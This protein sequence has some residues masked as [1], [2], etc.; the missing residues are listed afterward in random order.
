MSR[1]YYIG[2]D[3]GS[4][5]IKIV[6]LDEG[7]NILWSKYERTNGDP[8]S[9]LY[10]L[11]RQALD[12]KNILEI[13]YFSAI[14][15]TGS[16][17]SVI[18]QLL[19][20]HPINE[21]SSHGLAAGH[22]FPN[23][24]T[25]IE[26][27]GQD[28]KL[29]FLDSNNKKT[30]IIDSQMNDICAAG[31]GSFLD[32][33]AYRMGIT[34]EELSAK[35]CL[36]NNPSKISGRCSVFAKTDMIHLHQGGTSKEDVSYGLCLAVARTYIENLL[37]GRAVQKPI[38][39]QGG[40]A[41]NKGIKRAFKEL[42]EIS[43]EDIIIPNNFDLMGAIGTIIYGIEKNIENGLSREQLLEALEKS[44]II[45]D[46]DHY[47]PKLTLEN[48]N[49]I[50]I[51]PPSSMNDS[52][53]SGYIGIDIGSVSVKMAV[54][55]DDGKLFFSHYAKNTGDPLISLQECF[56][57][58][59]DG[60][61]EYNI[62]GVGVTGSGRDY[63]GK[64]LKADIV[65]NEI[66]AQVAGTRSQFAGV[67]VI[68]EI[69]GQDSKYIRLK[70]GI[71]DDFVMNKTCAAGTGSFL[72]EQADRL[73][74]ELNN[75]FS[76]FAMKAEKPVNIGSRCTV[77][78]ETDCIHYQQCGIAKEN[79]IAGLSYSIVKNYLEKVAINKSFEGCVAIQGGVANNVSVVA[80]F[81]ALLEKEI[82]ITPN[83]EIT[84]AIGIACIT[85]E[86]MKG[87]KS[88]FIGFNLDE[89]LIEKKHSQCKEC[90]N[91][92]NLTIT[93]FSDK[94]CTVTGAICGK[95]D[96]SN[97]NAIKK[98]NNY[99]ALRKNILE[100]YHPQE[101]LNSKGNI[102]IPRMLLYHELYPLWAT[103]FSELG[104]SVV[105]SDE[106]SHEVYKKGLSKVIVD[107]CFP[108]RCIYGT[109]TDLIDKKVDFIYL[110]YVLSMYDENYKTKYA[111]NCQ[112]IQQVPD[113]IKSSFDCNILSHTVR[114]HGRSNNIV[115]AF[116][117]LGK[118]LGE[119]SSETKRAYN[120]AIEAQ[121]EF[122][123]KCIDN[124]ENALK[125][126]S[127]FD[128]IFVLIGH[129]Y[130]IH[131]SF[132][133]MNLVERLN[134]IGIPT[135]S[136]DMLRL[137]EHTE[138]S[139]KIDLAWKTNNQAVNAIEF[140]H[141][142]NLQNRNKLLP[143][144]ITQFGCAADSMLTPYLKNFLGENNWLELEV[145][146]HN[147]ITGLLTRCEAFWESMSTNNNQKPG[148]NIAP[149]TINKT[150]M[151]KIKKESRTLYIY[152][153]CEAI[154]VLPHVL[155]KHGIKGKMIPKTTV[156]TNDVG[157]KYSNEKHCR[158][159]QVMIGDIISTVQEKSFL[160]EKSSILMFDYG[161][162]CRLALFTS[163]KS[164]ILIEQGAEA[165]TILNTTV[166]DP[167]GWILKF[168]IDLAI[169]I[170]CALICADYLSRYKF[171]IRPYEKNVGD[172]EKCYLQAVSILH[173]NISKGSPFKGFK[174][175]MNLMR[176]VELAE[177]DLVHVAVTG[178]AFT[179]VHDYGMA[180][181]YE[182]IEK[183]GGV[184]YLPPSWNDF[185]SYGANR[186]TSRL[187][188]KGHL[189]KAAVNHI[190]S[191][192]LTFFKN[193]IEKIA[194]KYSHLFL[195]PNISQLTEY[196]SEYVNPL[197]APVIPSMF[198]GK[199]VDFVE[200]KNIHGLVN[201]YGFNCCLG[202]ITTACINKLR[203]KNDNLPMF[204]FIDDGLEQTNVQTRIES[205]MEQ[206]VAYKER[207]N[208]RRGGKI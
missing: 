194:I 127:D 10:F 201:A 78:M 200:N 81:S 22:Y 161:E 208:A 125:E 137:K 191:S 169:E 97:K 27:G 128:R 95:Y 62:K 140:I 171:Q 120:K 26:I 49:F 159:F 139:K 204:T 86:E 142:Y 124:G 99:F 157:R 145:D 179:R 24:K 18:S 110:P 192:S 175:S 37:K 38:L 195:E 167:M 70:N 202:K 92:C 12:S 6:I 34:I 54:I 122:I 83:N 40:V 21:I 182:T 79:I 129:S 117:E 103:F 9:K 48:V 30:S 146:E 58:F 121:K 197:I 152:P 107:T 55:D 53:Y 158:T 185:I 33:Q 82:F 61:K 100:S 207:A 28:S 163:L 75:E 102:G 141:N 56:K 162:A 39:L 59:E 114:F 74:V 69:G 172:T 115:A 46:S 189:V 72:A 176:S 42:L 14:Y 130:I 67:D 25:V 94:D 186:H 106:T 108:I 91:L 5:S 52:A 118:N 17:R 143:V 111:H 29:I 3:C 151:N 45:D 101:Q 8:V 148:F 196:S 166:D 187:R 2:I 98:S 188:E 168:G 150:A 119:S 109:V 15:V 131:D 160:P 126:Y 174:E 165:V 89:R 1:K 93:S 64:C 4:V 190:N 84:G 43:D 11:L 134:M 138:I 23:A 170:W 153:I 181:I 116:V 105:L 132:F 193:R 180:E 135:I 60:V 63:I 123:E 51:P 177:R 76:D 90:S 65:K 57:A 41:N 7:L 173:N 88:S 13:S 66:T 144:F 77:F 47:L 203:N 147:S 183:L 71:V 199:T 178:D 206:A 31:T 184:I 87:R 154:E 104:Y 44:Y 96:K 73:Q 80:A 164:K 16:G 155:A 50:P 19:T 113:L 112:Y 68:I 136:S 32:Q 85:K 35:A 36:S 149:L 156:Q 198:I 205:F 20:A 133:N